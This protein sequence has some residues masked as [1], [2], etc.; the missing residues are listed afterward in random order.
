MSIASAWALA[1]LIVLVLPTMIHQAIGCWARRVLSPDRDTSFS[2]AHGAAFAIILNMIYLVV[3]GGT[4]EQWINLDGSSS[5]VLA[6][7]PRTAGLVTLGLY[8]LV[9]TTLSL[10]LSSQHIE[11][12]RS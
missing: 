1:M 4:V 10:I 2:V 11:L 12:T 7:T 9:P 6:A 5:P 8:V 3:F